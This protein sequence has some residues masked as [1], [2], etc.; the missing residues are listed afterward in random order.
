M[1]FATSRSK[2]LFFN[3][4]SHSTALLSGVGSVLNTGNASKDGHFCPGIDSASL[5]SLARHYN[6][7]CRILTR[8]SP[9]LQ[10]FKEPRY[11]FRGIDSA[12]L[13]SL[14]TRYDKLCCCTGPTG[15]ESIPG[16]IKRFTNT[17]SGFTG[18]RNRF[19][20]IDS[21]AP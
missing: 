21:W 12:S 19:F 11:R 9:Y 17:G 7:I 5:C 14:A 16:L 1:A 18:S 20:G 8:Q 10:T 2:M 15:W 13:C 3:C 4:K 6:P